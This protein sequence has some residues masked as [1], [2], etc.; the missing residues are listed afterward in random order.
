MTTMNPDVLNP[1]R[2]TTADNIASIKGSIGD[3]KESVGEVV[4]NEREHLMEK[5]EHGKEKARA[6]KSGLETFVREKPV[7]SLMIAAGA[8]ALLGYVLGRRR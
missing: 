1:Q 4:H 3:I 2:R 6:A 7:T 8:G 5:I